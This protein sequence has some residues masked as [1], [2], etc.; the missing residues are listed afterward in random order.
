M[1][2]Y[3]CQD[4]P[5]YSE[6]ELKS[7][8]TTIVRG[9]GNSGSKWWFWKPSL[10]SEVVILFFWTALS[11]L[12]AQESLLCYQTYIS[13]SLVREERNKI[14]TTYTH[15]GRKE[16]TSTVFPQLRP[17]VSVFLLSPNPGWLI[18][19]SVASQGHLSW[20]L[21]GSKHLMKAP[22]TFSTNPLLPS[23]WLGPK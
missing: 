14:L 17:Q 3:Q 10:L 2:A 18:L 22:F 15:T 4:I 11:Q 7:T 16:I 21:A 6:I 12:R 23:S 19:L 20:R 5:P 1:S 8:F 13:L 9:F